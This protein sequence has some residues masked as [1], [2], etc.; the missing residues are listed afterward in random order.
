MILKSLLGCRL[1]A[2]AAIRKSIPVFCFGLPD[3]TGL[4]RRFG[5]GG[6]LTQV[7]K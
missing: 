6:K 4:W 5:V 7:P 2:F 1:L 3:K